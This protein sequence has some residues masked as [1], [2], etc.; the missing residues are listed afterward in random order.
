MNRDG[1]LSGPGADPA[2]SSHCGKYA[3]NLPET[4]VPSYEIASIRAPFTTHLP[5]S[6][7]TRNISMEE[8]RFPSQ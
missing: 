3:K 6:L 1:K 4:G 7:T 5:F 2:G 8:L